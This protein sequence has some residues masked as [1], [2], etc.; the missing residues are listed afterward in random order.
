MS[1]HVLAQQYNS[2]AV[3]KARHVLYDD[4]DVLLWQV[5]PSFKVAALILG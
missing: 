1:A 2:T 4:D 3:C 5:T